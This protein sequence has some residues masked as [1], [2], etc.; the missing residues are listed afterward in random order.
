MRGSEAL[1]RCNAKMKRTREGRGDD[2][3]HSLDKAG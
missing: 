1:E 3:V 2:T